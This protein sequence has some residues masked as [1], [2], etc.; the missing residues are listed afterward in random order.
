MFDENEAFELWSLLT[1]CD[2]G[3]PKY[4]SVM[5]KLHDVR[6]GPQDY[7]REDLLLILDAIKEYFADTAEYATPSYDSRGLP[8]PS[9]SAVLAQRELLRRIDVR[10]RRHLGL[11][12]PEP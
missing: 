6:Y 9:V 3:T 5:Q 8:G 4:G 7:S 10:I 12:P 1:D 2:D 11:L